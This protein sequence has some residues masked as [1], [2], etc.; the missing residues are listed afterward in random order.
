[1]PTYG[2]FFDFSLLLEALEIL[3]MNIPS[4]KLVLLSLVL[5]K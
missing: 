2:T 1:M 3:T 4:S 5:R